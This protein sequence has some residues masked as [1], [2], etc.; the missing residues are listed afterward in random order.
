MDDKNQEVNWEQNSS[1]SNDQVASSQSVAGTTNN[2]TIDSLLTV[3]NN[4]VLHWDTGVVFYSM[5]TSTWSATGEKNEYQSFS[6]LTSIQIDAVRTAFKQW[7]SVCN[8]TMIEVAPSS[9][10]ANIKI[11]ESKVPNTSTTWQWWDSFGDMT[12][13]DVWYGNNTAYSPNNPVVGSYDYHTIMHEIGH[14]LGLKHPHDT[15]GYQVNLNDPNDSYHDSMA[16]TVMS[17]K[18]YTGASNGY[19]NGDDSYAYGPMMDDIAAVQ[20]LYGANYTY[21]AG[22]SVYKFDPTQ[23]KIFQTIWDGGGHDTYDLSAYTTNLK[24]DLRPGQWSTFDSNQLAD[25]G[26]GNTAPGNVANALLYN[27]DTRSL[28]EN[29]IGG[30]GNDTLIGNQADNI[31]NGGAGADYMAGGLGNDT[32]VVDNVGDV[33]VENP[34]EGIDTVYSN[35]AT[36]ILGANVENLILYGTGNINGNGNELNNVIT[37][38]SGN[39]ILDGGSGA[40]T[41]IGGMGNDTYV[42]DNV[43]D[44]VVE[45]AGEGIDTVLSSIAYTLGA[46]VE[47]LTL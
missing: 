22:D 28:I 45:N 35:L 41:M 27:G 19:T 42:V 3:N 17:Y 38:N 30:T 24:V 33:V 44:V 25:L 37:G 6:P 14:A 2:P 26:N 36:S 47:N 15:D 46:N 21:N 13:A 31:L 23:S 18:S 29:A 20:Y 11:G 40:D 9:S 7:G 12:K 43:S 8:L 16:Y 34:G 10:W 4:K 1:S 39:N 5:P 32:Y